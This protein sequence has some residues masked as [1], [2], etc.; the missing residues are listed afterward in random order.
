MLAQCRNNSFWTIMQIGWKVPN[1]YDI[2]EMVG[3]KHCTQF[4]HQSTTGDDQ[5]ASI[6]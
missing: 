1:F 2:C 4:G 6:D 3:L 5:R